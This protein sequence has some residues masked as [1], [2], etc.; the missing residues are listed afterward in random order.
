LDYLSDLYSETHAGG[1][2]SLTKALGSENLI[3]RVSYTLES[4]D[5]QID[6]SRHTGTNFTYSTNTVVDVTN[7][8][9]TTTITTNVSPANISQDIYD[10]GG[11]RLVSK[12]GTS[13]A[14]DTRNSTFLATSGQR[15]ELSTEIAGSYLG[16]D[17]DFYKLEAK[18]VWY[19]PGFF[20]GHVIEVGGEMGVVSSYGN[21]DRGKD[22][23]PI[24]DRWFLGGL[25]SL[26]GYRYRDVGPQDQFGEPLGGS[27]YWF[28]SIEYSLPIIERLRFAM[29]Y[30]IGN[31]YSQAYSFNPG[32][33]RQ[34]RYLGDERGLYED[35]WGIGL[36]INIPMLG[37]LRL[38]YGFPM[39][40]DKNLGSSG[41][42]NFGVGFQSRF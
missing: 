5:V 33:I 22:R 12:I 7:N 21:G 15:T 18:S 24:F 3:G 2:L 10:E 6:H 26:R 13:L 38:D 11:R 39:T 9:S 28:S 32:K 25:Y 42:F 8:T 31:V 37:P 34:P 20:E 40:H 1:S 41:R 23:V 16:G 35:N 36:R 17:T 4:I 27:T 30:D 29:F 19:F 14:Y